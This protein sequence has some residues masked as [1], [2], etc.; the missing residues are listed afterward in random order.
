MFWG[1][2]TNGSCGCAAPERPL[3]WQ[4]PDLAEITL[5]TRLRMAGVLVH[6]PVGSALCNARN[7][8]KIGDTGGH[9][10]WHWRRMRDPNW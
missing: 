8:D 10:H 5:K 3:L 9:W 6:L 2:E 1:R 7:L 4:Q